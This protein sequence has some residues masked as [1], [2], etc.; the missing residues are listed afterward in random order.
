M[1]V[2]QETGLETPLHKNFSKFK[3]KKKNPQNL[4]HIV[5]LQLKHIQKN[6]KNKM[7]LHSVFTYNWVDNRLKVV[8]IVN[9]KTV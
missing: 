6:K 7:H 9:F 1:S 4:N 3:K 2:I 5:I 8:I